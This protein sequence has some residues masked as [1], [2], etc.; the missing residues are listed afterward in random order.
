MAHSNFWYPSRNENN[1]CCN[2]YIALIS[3]KLTYKLKS[4]G[5][6]N[7]QLLNKWPSNKNEFELD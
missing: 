4:F 5:V 2:G 1:F 7:Y 3:E 6:K